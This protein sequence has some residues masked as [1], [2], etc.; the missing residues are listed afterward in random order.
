MIVVDDDLIFFDNLIQDLMDKYQSDKNVIWTGWCQVMNLS[1][2]GRLVYDVTLNN[3]MESEVPSFR[4]K[5][6]SGS[7]TLIPEY[8]I[9]DFDYVLKLIH[10]SDNVYHDELILKKISMDKG[11]KVGLCKNKKYRCNIGGWLTPTQF[12]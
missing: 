10:S 12:I 9:D 4:Y 5:F 11:I 6:G 2:D 7:G 1:D 3:N 8:M